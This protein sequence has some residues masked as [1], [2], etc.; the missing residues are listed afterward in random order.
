MPRVGMAEIG[1]LNLLVYIEGVAKVDIGPM[2]VG[3]W[4]VDKATR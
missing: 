4:Q 1:G 3:Q 2:N